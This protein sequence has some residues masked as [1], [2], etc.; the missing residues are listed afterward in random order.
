LPGLSPVAMQQARFVAK[1]IERDL[2]NK[3]RGEFSYFDK[4]TMSTIGRSRAVAE[5][6]GIKMSGMIAWLAW[7][8]VHLWFLIG[9]RNRVA[10][11]LTWIWSYVTYGRGARLITG[12][13][14][15]DVREKSE[16]ALG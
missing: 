8:F 7:L 13:V 15:D 11:M 3:P 6:K 14:G 2:A 12:R 5:A 9:F 16:S 10:V 1:A 4:G